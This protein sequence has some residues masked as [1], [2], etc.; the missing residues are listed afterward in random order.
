[1]LSARS[2]ANRSSVKQVSPKSWFKSKQEILG[3]N[4]PVPDEFS[5][6]FGNAF[7]VVPLPPYTAPCPMLTEWSRL[8]FSASSGDAQLSFRPVLYKFA[9]QTM[10]IW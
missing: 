1:M 2:L 5:Y 9:R 4:I 8:V 3:K 6:S 7:H 10:G